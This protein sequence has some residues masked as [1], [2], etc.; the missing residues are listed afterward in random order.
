MRLASEISVR[1]VVV[2]DDQPPLSEVCVNAVATGQRVDGAVLEAAVEC[3]GRYLLFLT[4]DVPA[5]DQLSIHLVDRDGRLLDSARIG[6]MYSTGSFSS[7]TFREPNAAAFRF[8]GDAD[9]VV[10]VFDQPRWQ[11]PFVAEPRGVSRPWRWRRWFRV[12]GRP[13]PGP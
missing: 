8:I 6:A 12:E 7:L 2:N 1:P 9:W 3:N 13:S 10:R 11:M 4:D 5:E